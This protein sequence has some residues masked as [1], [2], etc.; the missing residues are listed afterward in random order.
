M[1]NG[2]IRSGDTRVAK[3]G[4]VMDR[5]MGTQPNVDGY[6]VWATVGMRATPQDRGAVNE[7]V[8]VSSTTRPSGSVPPSCTTMKSGSREPK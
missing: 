3:S 4:R 5:Y 2:L 1:G 6:T 7:T 8:T